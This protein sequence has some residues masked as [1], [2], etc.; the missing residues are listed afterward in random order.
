VIQRTA[1]AL[2]TQREL[3]VPDGL[4][5]N[6]REMLTNLANTMQQMRDFTVAQ[7]NAWQLRTNL[8]SN[9]QGARSGLL[10]Q[11]APFIRSADIDVAARS[12]SIM[13]ALGRIRALEAEA[14]KAVDK[15]R[16]ASGTVG[17]AKLSAHYLAAENDHKKQA[18]RYLLAVVIVAVLTVVLAAILFVTLKVDLKEHNTSTQWAE[19]TRS[20]V[21]RL[22]FLGLAS[23][24][25]AFTIRNYKVNRHLQVSNAQKRIALDTYGLFTEAVADA[26]LRDVIT[27]E[28]VKAVFVA[29][30]TGFLDTGSDK[31]VIESSD[32]ATIVSLLARRGTP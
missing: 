17:A 25:L 6:A 15:I 2:D 27:A 8:I 1:Q 3:E 32:A 12:T 26:E 28:L 29:P 24:A 11:C 18:G 4:F 31:T 30:D 23:Y 13:E 16:V 21:A 10:Q 9:V 22:F 5:G 20:L 14:D 19:L 7:D